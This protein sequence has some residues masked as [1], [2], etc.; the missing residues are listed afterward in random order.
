MNRTCHVHHTCHS[1]LSHHTCHFTPTPQKP[2]AKADNLS[3]A[4]RHLRHAQPYPPTDRPPTDRGIL[5]VEGAH[6][7]ANEPTWGSSTRWL[8][9]VG[10]WSTAVP[11]ALTS[12]HSRSFAHHTLTSLDRCSHLNLRSLHRQRPNTQPYLLDTYTSF[13]LTP[14][15]PQPQPIFM[16]SPT[17]IG[18]APHDSPLTVEQHT[19]SL[20]S[21]LP[22]PATIVPTPRLHTPATHDSNPSIPFLHMYTYRSLL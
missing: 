15:V 21:P 20:H 18:T 10:G 4:R 8:L 14:A 22:P 16:T 2:R 5:R 12:N 9:H 1:H 17:H 3:G 11:A 6:A 19:S 13:H 7:R